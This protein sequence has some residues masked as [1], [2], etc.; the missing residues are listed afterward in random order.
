MYRLLGILLL[1]AL[2]GFL[3]HRNFEIHRI[4]DGRCLSCLEW[5]PDDDDGKDLCDAC[6]EEEDD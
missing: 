2:A 1:M 3:F 4:E 6:Q 5:I